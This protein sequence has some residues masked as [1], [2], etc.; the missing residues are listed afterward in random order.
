MS[1][2]I[3]FRKSDQTGL[4]RFAV[5]GLVALALSGCVANAPGA[6]SNAPAGRSGKAV[7]GLYPVAR[8]GQD[9]QV[10]VQ[11]G[12]TGK[13]L[14]RSGAQSVAGLSLRVTRAAPALRADEG[15]TAKQVARAGCAQ[16][17]GK[18]NER[19][20]GDFQNP[21]AWVFAGGCA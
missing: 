16:A 9:Y 8:A 15:L 17:G 10:A 6:A 7:A 4:H 12:G 11:A 13:V 3:P 2:A 18:L 21:P 1:C 20:I 5:A 19:A 14:T